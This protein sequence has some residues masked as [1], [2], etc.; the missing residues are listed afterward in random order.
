MKYPINCNKCN[1]ALY[2]PVKYCPFC[3]VQTPVAHAVKEVS[4][5]VDIGQITKESAG[6]STSP[7][8]VSQETISGLD[9][10][11]KVS[12]K[13]EHD[14]QPTDEIPVKQS[15]E[16]IIL[17]EVKTP[18]KK[19]ETSQEEKKPVPIASSP[20]EPGPIPKPNNLK[21]IIVAVVLVAVVI[22]GYLFFHKKDTPPPPNDS[23]RILALDALRMGT[24]LSVTISNIPRLEKN[25][26]GAKEL[27]DIS[28]RYQEQVTMAENTLKS[29]LKNRD[30]N[31]LAYFGKVVELR[32]YK[33]DQISYAM[34][35]INNGDRTL[36][37][38]KV[39]ELLTKHVDYLSKN[40]ETDPKKL[41]SDFNMQFSDFVD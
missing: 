40:K 14:P 27:G 18:E 25:L 22:S 33:T 38:K 30:K 34:R 31:L 2:G 9:I 29:A 12:K 7:D 3:G 39:I 13:P 6:I 16:K 20:P 23:A 36:R 41:L 15:E 8:I 19:E 10:E 21:W 4:N 37:E 35:I 24:D 28:P 17:P 32:R 11:K 26:K 1:Q 5:K